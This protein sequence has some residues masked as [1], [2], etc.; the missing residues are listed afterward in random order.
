M[1]HPLNMLKHI[2]G[3]L[4]DQHF[5]SPARQSGFNGVTRIMVEKPKSSRTKVQ[6]GQDRRKSTQRREPEKG[7]SQA[8]TLVALAA[9]AEKFHDGSKEAY[10]RIDQDGH[11]EVWRIGSKAFKYWLQRKF[12]M[13]MGT[14]PNAQALQDAI[15]V[16]RGQAIFDGQLRETAVRISGNDD[17]V[18]LDL[19]NEK[20]QAVRIDANGWQIVDNPDVTF[21]RPR[22]VLPLPS[23]H[24]D[25]WHLATGSSW[26]SAGLR[27]FCLVCGGVTGSWLGVAAKTSRARRREFVAGSRHSARIGPASR[28]LFSTK[29]RKLAT[30]G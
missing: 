3:L 19:A 11:R 22:G 7:D 10:A 30:G 17:C 18:W 9:N 13:V 25:W 6:T 29:S 14:A 4:L 1:K 16:L 21:V 5:H 8:T 2:G 28:V 20:W 27:V 26:Q 15:G 24:V 12:W 23:R